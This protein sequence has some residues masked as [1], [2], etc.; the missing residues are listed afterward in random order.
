MTKR[1]IYILIS[2][3]GLLACA[4]WM[5]LPVDGDRFGRKGFL[6]GLDLK[7]GSHLVYEAD[8]TKK[9]PSQTDEQVMEGVTQKIERRANA[10]GV[11]EPLIQREGTNRIIVQLPGIK[12]I[13]EAVNLIGQV[14]L[15]EFK[16]TTPDAAGQ[17]QKTEAGDIIWKT[18]TA[19]G[20]DGKEKELTGKYLKPNSK[21][22]LTRSTNQPEVAFEWNDEG[23]VLFEQITKRNL[24]KPLGIFLDNQLISAPTVEAVIK[25]TGIITCPD[26][27]EAQDLSIQLN[28]GSLDVPLKVVQRMDVDATLGADSLKKSLYAGFVGLALVALFMLL[29]YR[30][31]G[32]L[33]VCAL[34]VYGSVSLAI[35][36]LIPITLTLPAIAGFIIS[37]GM[38]VDANILVFERMKEELRSGRTLAAAVEE[39]FKRAWPSIR[40]SNISTF[41]TC[42]ILYWFGGTFG[43]F[44]VQGF[45][46]TLFLGVVVSMFSALI[47]T[48]TFL[49]VLVGSRIVTS[50]PAYGVS[51]PVTAIPLADKSVT[52]VIKAWSLDFVGKRYWF[53]LASALIIIPGIISLGIFH[54]KP[55]VDFSSGTAMTIH[56]S[57]EVDQSQL[58]QVFTELGY[59]EA[60]IQH[61][62]TGDYLVRIPAVTPEEKTALTDG[63]IRKTGKVVTV[64]DFYAVSPIVAGET[65]G[66]AVIAVIAAALGILLYISF[67]F[68]KMPKPIR[69]GTCAIVAMIHDVLL[70]LGVFSILGWVLGV[71]IDAMFITAMLTVVGYSVHDTIV[72]F[73]RIREN[74]RNNVHRDFAA[75]VNSG[76]VE[77]L[78][79]SINTSFTVILVVMALL[80]LGG[81]TIHYFI[82]ALLIGV[83][84]GTYSSIGNA[85]QLLVV[86]EKGIKQSSSLGGISQMPN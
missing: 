3:L 2:I 15:L 30:L 40:D 20:S 64:R 54:L 22:S 56:L 10:Y 29:Y 79:R 83:I 36:K 76:I 13:D 39:G 12:N 45:A 31:P 50:L 82:L 57:E 7:G 48:R 55:G 46:I 21:V 9:D 37:I 65:A 34:L 51:A 73:D 81:T 35:F 26:L 1:N 38:A 43:A 17:P 23:A 66:N 60:I 74:M 72:V 27:K 14:A 58:R 28:S 84:T 16:E 75:T 47:V 63:L 8:L 70:V 18:A 86:W 32:L 85:S 5:V 71:E 69:W 68:R 52:P 11:T 78:V 53:F 67:A 49:R 24:Q 6:L 77:T 59:S 44:M 33:A 80:L 42:F 62:G 41:I 4:V 61:T 19:I 25:N